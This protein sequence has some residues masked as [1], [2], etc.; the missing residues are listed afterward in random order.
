M[1]KPKRP[2]L[3]TFLPCLNILFGLSALASTASLVARN[4]TQFNKPP[5]AAPDPPPA[6]AESKA[7]PKMTGMLP[8]ATGLP[9]PPQ[10]RPIPDSDVI[11]I[12]KQ[13]Q[14]WFSGQVLYYDVYLTVAAVGGLLL[15]TLLLGSGIGL[16]LLNPA[17]QRMAIGF[18]L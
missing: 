4:Y 8:R 1:L 14:K 17:G 6:D 13:Q 2:F 10:A 18:A 16:F 11:G 9:M 15:G 12:L 3:V 5:P 7:P